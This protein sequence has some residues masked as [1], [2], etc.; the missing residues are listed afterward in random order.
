VLRRTA[1]ALAA[2]LFVVAAPSAAY[3]GGSSSKPSASVALGDSYI[4]GEAGRWQ[5]NSINPVGDRDGTDR[6]CVFTAT[7]CT[8]Y[9]KSL[10]YVDGSDADGCHRS[11]VSEILSATIP[12]DQRINIACSGAVTANIFRSSNGGE[13]AK[14]EAPEADQLATVAHDYNVKLVVL[15]IGGNDL[16]FAAIVQACL[17]AYLSNGTPCSQS[18][19]AGFRAKM[20]TAMA[21]VA[22]AIDE[23]RA[24]MSA[25][26]YSPS[27]YR[28]VLQ[29][30]P[31][32]LSRASENRYAEADKVGRGA[33]GGCPVYDVDADWARDT[34]VP[35][36]SSN[37][38]AVA[39][40]RGVQFMDLRDAFQGREIC[41]RTTSQPS[42]AG[43]SAT[44]SE[45]GR[46]LTG[47]TVTQGDLQEA[48]HPNAY[49]EKA[50]GACL[51]LVYG[52]SASARGYACRNTP[53]AGTSAMTIA[54][55]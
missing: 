47:E 13:P 1:L 51:K 44:G 6:A 11:D 10:V 20:P 17:T 31:S 5:G 55:L 33:I 42:S 9:D 32:V 26:G 4:S 16:G 3:A 18:E 25:Q 37:L 2:T 23:I 43:P 24:V 54:R 30:Y 19:D 35:L 7:L 41:A 40:Q 53:G 22:K 38:K 50:I 39:A 8:S 21:G 45:W 52:A 29:S 36:I 46:F 14:G 34:V 27:R 49:G 48:I 15:S 28:F 12:V